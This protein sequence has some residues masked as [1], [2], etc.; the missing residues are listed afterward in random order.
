MN[1]IRIGGLFSYCVNDLI[2]LRTLGGVYFQSIQNHLMENI[3]LIQ[4]HK[5]PFANQLPASGRN[6]AISRK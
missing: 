6:R 3:L 4:V 2:L 5:L 1:Q